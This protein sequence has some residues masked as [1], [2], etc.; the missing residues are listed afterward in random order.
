M[1]RC[2]AMLR[3]LDSSWVD[4]YCSQCHFKKNTLEKANCLAYRD[5]ERLQINRESKISVRV[6]CVALY[7]LLCLAF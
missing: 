3:V 1:E 5:I 7:S 6:V 4:G 2:K